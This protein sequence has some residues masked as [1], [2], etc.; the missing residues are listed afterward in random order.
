MKSIFHFVAANVNSLIL[1]KVGTAR[2]AILRRRAQHTSPEKTGT[3]QHSFRPAGR[4]RRCA[5]SLPAQTSVKDIISQKQANLPFYQVKLK[6]DLIKVREGTCFVSDQISFVGHQINFVSDQINFVSDQ[7]SFVS[8]QI[9]FIRD[10]INFVSDQISFIRDQ[11]SFVSDQISFVS[12]ETYR[13][14]DEK[15][16]SEVNLVGEMI[17]WRSNAQEWDSYDQSPHKF[18]RGDEAQIKKCQSRFTSAATMGRL[19]I[20]ISNFE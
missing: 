11:I 16:L 12:H 14:C 9:S 6:A 3:L 18:C 8:D 4:G 10:Q 2:C 13:F 17:I 7:I 5:A 20:L 19:K 1:N 15:G